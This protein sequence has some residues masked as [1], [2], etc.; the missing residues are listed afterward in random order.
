M[1]RIPD[2]SARAAGELRP[3]DSYSR[4]AAFHRKPIVIVPEMP[5]LKLQL[6][7]VAAL[8]RQTYLWS[9]SRHGFNRTRRLTKRQKRTN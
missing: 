8:K 4:L 7:L 1:R 2:Q 6:H 9:D 5:A 3:S